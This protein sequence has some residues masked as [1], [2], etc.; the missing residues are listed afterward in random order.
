MRHSKSSDIILVDLARFRV[1]GENYIANFFQAQ[2]QCYISQTQ[3][4]SGVPNGNILTAAPGYLNTY[5]ALKREY[6]WEIKH[7]ISIQKST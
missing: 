1:V 7:F 6:N 3:S 5:L 2:W 4:L